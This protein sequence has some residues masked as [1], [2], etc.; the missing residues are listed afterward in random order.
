MRSRVGRGCATL[1]QRSAWVR[2]GGRVV[3]SALCRAGRCCG[4]ASDERVEL[5][6]AKEIATLPRWAMVAF[7][8]RCAQRVRPLL[9]PAWPDIPNERLDAVDRAI[10]LARASAASPASASE[11]HLRLVADDAARTAGWAVDRASE[12]GE[13]V[14]STAVAATDVAV[15]AVVGE[16]DAVDSVSHVIDHANEAARHSYYA[17]VS[18]ASDSVDIG[19]VALAFRT[20]IRRD[21][22][23]LRRLAESE[24]WTDE[25][26]VDVDRLGPLW[27]EG[28]PEGWPEDTEF[29]RRDEQLLE[30]GFKLPPMPDRAEVRAALRKKLIGVL[31][32]ANA[33]HLAEGGSGLKIAKAKMYSGSRVRSGGGDDV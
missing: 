29:E 24:G 7:A 1:K 13:H 19:L 8:V 12:A 26:G 32:S 20:A 28:V 21:F 31:T 6:S 25:T 17:A 3:A 10:G 18:E 16:L 14:A 27:P 5:P 33:M 23:V 9:E 4:M 11:A 30:I 2:E 15:F 22:D